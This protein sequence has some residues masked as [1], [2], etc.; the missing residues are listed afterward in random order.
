MDPRTRRR[1]T[2][3]IRTSVSTWSAASTATA[4]SA[5]A[6]R[7]KGSSRGASSIAALSTHL[8]PD[9]GTTLLESSCVSC[10]ACVDACPSGALLD[11]SV[12]AH[13]RP[14]EWTRTTC[15]YCG[16]GCEMHVGTRGGRIVEIRPALDAKVN[17]GHLCA[18][19]RYAYDFVAS[20]DRVTEP[21]IRE[22]TGWRTASWDEA[23]ALRRR[24][25]PRDRGARRARRDR[26][27]RLRARD[28][29]RGLRRTEARPRRDRHEQR[30]LL[31]PRLPR[32][33]CGGLEGDVRHRCGDQFVR[34]RRARADDPRR[35]EQR[36]LV[37]SDRRRTD[38]TSR[39]AWGESRR[40]RHTTHR[41]RGARDGAPRASTR[42]RP[43]A[44]PR[45]GARRLRRGARRRAVPARTRRRSRRVPRVPR[46]L[47]ARPRGRDRRRRG[48]RHSSRRAAPRDREARDVAPRSR[49]HRTRTR[50]RHA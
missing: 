37:P 1:S 33:E 30:R 19:G 2:R 8:V 50:H 41:A 47:R 31:R 20:D 9:S 22:G 36:H 40:R 49:P 6:A 46:G 32:A 29:R 25:A 43:R 13:G 35:R 45:D 28:E 38:Q 34:G 23:I 39:A 17:H 18:K 44:L 10:G 11:A 14:T 7:S 26:R 48:R 3:R 42:D 16:V 21:R 5:S 12:V 4:A 27:A 24:Q 15:A